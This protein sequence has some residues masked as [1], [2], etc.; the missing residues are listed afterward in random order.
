MPQAANV[1][2]ENAL[3]LD[4]LGM[5]VP[6]LPLTGGCYC[7]AIRY[8]VR[9]LPLAVTVCHCRDCQRLTGSAFSMP[10][11]VPQHA[12]SLTQGTSKSWQRTADSGNVS[13][14]HFCG[15]CGTRLYTE[16]RSIPHV[17]TIRAGTLDETS[18]LKPV[19]QVWTKSAQPWACADDLLSYE[20]NPTDFGSILQAWKEAMA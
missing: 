20:S 2:V 8:E 16:A 1:L 9:A 13:T 10:M 18:W 15:G 12:F 19:A 7:G 11:V 17:V 3:A 14:Q 4:S 6:I 5:N